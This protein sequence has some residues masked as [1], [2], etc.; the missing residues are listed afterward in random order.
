MTD[1][2]EKCDCRKPDVNV[3]EICGSCGNHLNFEHLR[4][5]AVN[6]YDRDGQPIEDSNLPRRH[7]RLDDPSNSL[8]LLHLDD[9]TSPILSG[10]FQRV[11]I[12]HLPS[13]EAVSYCWGGD[14]GDYT[15]P[16]FII[17]GGRLFPITKNCAAA[18]RKVRETS[19]EGVI[20]I[21]SLCINQN[22]VK[23]RSVQVSQMGKIYSGA[24]KVHIYLGNNVDDRTASEAFFVLNSAHGFSMR[25]GSWAMS[26][27]TLFAQTYFSRMWVIQ[28]VLLAKSAQLY[29]GTAT[30]RWK[31]LSEGHL[32][33][34]KKAGI[35]DD[36]PDWIRIQA[37]N[38]NLRNSEA[39]GE[40]LFSAMGS[41]ASNDRDKVYGIYGLLFDAEVEG[42]TVDYGLSVKSVFTNM[43]VHLIR[44]HNALPAV[45]RHVSPDAPIIEG[46]QLPSW[47]PDF[48]SRCV[49]RSVPLSFDGSSDLEICSSISSEEV[50]F[51][52]AKDELHLRGHILSIFDGWRHTGSTEYSRVVQCTIGGQK[53]K[54]E[55]RA[56]FPVAYDPK[57]HTVFWMSNGLILHLEQRLSSAYAAYRVLGVCALEHSGPFPALIVHNRR[58]SFADAMFPL[59]LLQDLTSLWEIYMDFKRFIRCDRG[60]EV[61]PSGLLDTRLDWEGVDGAVSAYR[62][63]CSR[64]DTFNGGWR[65]DT[66]NAHKT[67]LDFEGFWE[68]QATWTTLRILNTG[69]QCFMGYDNLKITQLCESW[70]QSYERAHHMIKKLSGETGQDTASVTETLEEL[71]AWERT[72]KRL[73]EALQWTGWFSWP[74][75]KP[76]R[77]PVYSKEDTK[78]DSEEDSEGDSEEDSEEED[79]ILEDSETKQRDAEDD[80]AKASPHDKKMTPDWA[81]NVLKKTSEG[82]WVVVRVETWEGDEWHGPAKDR[83]CP[84]GDKWA[85]PI[86]SIPHLFTAK[87]QLNLEKVFQL[88]EICLK[89][90]AWRKERMAICQ[91]EIIILV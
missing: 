61:K 40:L 73:S 59:E 58:T 23:E 29:W 48:R 82:D 68:D 53:L 6:T 21:D 41:N 56:Q 80:E 45:L 37:I 11:S 87:N 60:D 36:I 63:F 17:V 18:L 1:V 88:E 3:D 16:E 12:T 65:K 75:G 84:W 70:V 9:R 78:E 5:R 24:Q 31:A 72:T 27:K 54:W 25:H 55:I 28:E 49:P 22:D 69:L 46:E 33:E 85:E 44:N 77:V 32:E 62:A 86:R 90:R 89:R 10:T 34:F 8:R 39:F 67:M 20:W 52:V 43:A 50:L 42:L 26:V 30:V 7:L 91:A 74:F 57:Q 66:G 19:K 76:Y 47:V 14:D 83:L 35:D 13:Y 51:R 2:Q 64:E 71:E 79:G 4:Q 81:M 38:K 15:K